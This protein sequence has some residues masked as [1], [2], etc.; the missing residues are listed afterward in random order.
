MGNYFCVSADRATVVKLFQVH[1]ICLLLKAIVCLMSPLL[2]TE[3]S[4]KAK[5]LD[6]PHNIPAVLTDI[7][8]ICLH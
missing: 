3:L 7:R 4:R 5:R 1:E 8:F 6:A 2:H